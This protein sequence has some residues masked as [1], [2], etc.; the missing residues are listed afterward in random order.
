MKITLENRLSL[1][2]KRMIFLFILTLFVF[3]TYIVIQMPKKEP[4]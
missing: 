1:F 3:L 4:D 2:Q